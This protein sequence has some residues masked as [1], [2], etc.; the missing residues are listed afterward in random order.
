MQG[1]A[2]EKKKSKE[3]SLTFS[4]VFLRLGTVLQAN[5][6]RTFVKW[7]SLLKR[8]FLIILG[9]Q[10]EVSEA[11]FPCVLLQVFTLCLELQ[12]IVIVLT[13]SSYTYNSHY[14]TPDCHQLHVQLSLS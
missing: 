7:H 10:T 14:F 4:S 13:A 9:E 6:H 1:A 8:R 3:K 5:T 11:H 2:T 12:N